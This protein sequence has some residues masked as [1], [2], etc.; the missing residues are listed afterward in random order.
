[1]SVER[2]TLDQLADELEAASDRW[3]NSTIRHV[4][5]GGD[6]RIVG[7]HFRESDTALCVEYT[8]IRSTFHNRVKFAR[9]VEEMDFGTK[10]VFT[11]GYLK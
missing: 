5:S 9:S 7:V 10:F 1:M 11:G 4:K 3:H 2:K 8:P 6:Y